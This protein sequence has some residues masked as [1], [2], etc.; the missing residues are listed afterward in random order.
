MAVQTDQLFAKLRDMKTR[1]DAG[2]FSGLVIDITKPDGTR[3]KF[4]GSVEELES[5]AV[6]K[7]FEALDLNSSNE[8]V[9]QV[10]QLVSSNEIAPAVSGEVA[11]RSSVI[12]SHRSKPPAGFQKS[13]E[14]YMKEA[15]LKPSTKRTYRSRLMFAKSFFKDRLGDQP[16]VVIDQT[17]VWEYA[18]FVTLHVSNETTAEHYL[19]TLAGFLN[20]FRVRYTKEF[21][22]ISTQKLLSRE[23]SRPA[24]DER[25]AF[26]LEDVEMLFENARRYRKRSPHKYWATIAIPFLGCR[27]EELAQLDLTSDLRRDAATGLWYL[28]LNQDPDHDGVVRKSLKKLASWR[29]V[30]IHSALVKHGF[31][32]YL[33]SQVGQSKDSKRPFE[34]RW[35]PWVPKVKSDEADEADEASPTATEGEPSLEVSG[36]V[37]IK[38][39]QY[40]TNWGGRELAKV[41]K[42]KASDGK[43]FDISNK[44]YFHS[45][46]H[47]FKQTLDRAGVSREISEALSGRR[48]AGM[49]EER[50]RKLQ[51]DLSVLSKD[52][53]EAGLDKLV[54]LL[55]RA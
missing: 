44:T 32:E 36:S 13:Y 55:Q 28:S 1:F 6:D 20:W 45:L 10:A 37:G 50:Y 23:Q 17:W 29:V 40:I 14:E 21:V 43:V 52:G 3:L 19:H 49:D 25:D 46:R 48:Y 39:S 53:I 18:K 26:S 7:I 12:A 2:S 16:V 35:K 31:V 5:A 38:W 47:T 34:D 42:Q 24:A 22:P 33:R 11:Q 9:A 4:D 51:K 30:P 27:I 54:D 41:A 15:G 8:K